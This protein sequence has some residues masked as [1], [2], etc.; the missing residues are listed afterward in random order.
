MA[1]G[2]PLGTNCEPLLEEV[3][4]ENLLNQHMCNVTKPTKFPKHGLIFMWETGL[5]TST[6]MD[7]THNG[8][9]RWPVL[10]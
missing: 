7:N 9:M 4:E 3:N 10:G 2:I 8:I 6:N 1:G 5:S